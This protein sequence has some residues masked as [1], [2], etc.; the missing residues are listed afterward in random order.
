MVGSILGLGP[1]HFGNETK[2]SPAVGVCRRELTGLFAISECPLQDCDD[3]YKGLHGSAKRGV[4]QPSK[5]VP[6]GLIAPPSP[7]NL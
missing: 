4:R 1:S 6:K 5:N 2:H 3:T 7:S